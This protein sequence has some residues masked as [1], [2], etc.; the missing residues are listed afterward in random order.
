MLP[1]ASRYCVDA[2]GT[3]NPTTPEAFIKEMPP[4]TRMLL[5][6]TFVT[7]L[8]IV[9]GWFGVE[10]FLLDWVLVYKQMHI[11]RLFTDYLFIGPFSIGWL[12]H[13]YF[14]VQFSSK[15]ERHAVFSR[16]ARD[17][18]SFLYFIVL[19]MIFLDSISLLLYAPHGK[20]LL[21]H[22]LSFAVIYYWSKKEAFTPTSLWG[23]TVLAWQLPYAL[24]VLDLLMGQ[25]LWQDLMG[26]LSGHMYYFIRDILPVEKNIHLL[27]S[28]PAIFGYLTSK[29]DFTAPTPAAPAT[30]GMSFQS[31][32]TQEY[33]AGTQPRVSTL[34]DN[35]AGGRSTATS[36]SA[37]HF[38]GTG[39]RVGDGAP[40]ESRS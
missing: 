26:L 40:E 2:Q 35:Q 7:T 6:A 5:G 36:R 19:Q 34:F 25:S 4:V 9:L 20:P 8:G 39:Y 12:F 15:L 16:H 27:A 23:F 32:G 37:H 11:W 38:P 22:S 24:L 17:A 29:L 1:P 30:A 21:G 18:G 3:M 28:T 31:R 13:M 14:F 10:H 33:S